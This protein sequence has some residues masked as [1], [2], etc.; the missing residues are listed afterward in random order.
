ML[1]KEDLIKL[2]LSEEVAEKVEKEL[3]EAM[4]GYIPKAR[5]DE[6]NTEKNK[7]KD[8]VA[9]RDKQLEDLKKSTG[10]IEGL[11][12]QIEDLQ[13]TNKTAAETHAAEVK[14]LKINAAV[15]AALSSAKAKNIKAVKA[16]LDLD[17]AELAEDGT[18][19]GLD[20]Q[21]KKLV[22]ADDSK[23]LFDSAKSEFK[24]KGAKVAEGK[25]GLPGSDVDFSKMSYEEMEAY[26][27]ENPDV[28][29]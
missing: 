18:V 1:K 8:T 22:G 9:E 23:F 10:D 4:K 24:P 29:I 25:D 21:L 26:L 28:K 13:T 17:K 11:K 3:T 2:G 7:L 14:Q 5:F 6:V 12:K 19:K 16:L 15:D 20:D 27:V